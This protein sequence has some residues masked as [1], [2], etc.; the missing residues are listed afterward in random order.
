MRFTGATTFFAGSHAAKISSAAKIAN[1]T[2]VAQTL[3]LLAPD[4]GLPSRHLAGSDL[5]SSR[6]FRSG[7]SSLRSA[8]DWPCTAFSARFHFVAALLG[9]GL[10]LFLTLL[11]FRFHLFAALGLA[12]HHSCLRAFIS[13]G[14]SG[15]CLA[16]LALSGAFVCNLRRR[17]DAQWHRADPGSRRRNMSYQHSD[18][19]NYAGQYVFHRSLLCDC[20]ELISAQR[21]WPLDLAVGA[22]RSRFRLRRSSS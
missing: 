1:K 20:T 3:K 11:H 16:T 10:A 17:Q 8:V 15:I 14:I 13:R 19:A 7:L 6:P 9:I 18:C 5:H 12:L 22:S 2:P 4:Y 21:C